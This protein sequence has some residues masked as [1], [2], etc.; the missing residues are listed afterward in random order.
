[1]YKTYIA[2]TD[3]LKQALYR[4]RYQIFTMEQRKYRNS[5]DHATQTLV[6]AIDPHAEH[7][8]LESDGNLIGSMRWLHG[9]EHLP[10]T[11]QD[12]LSLARFSKFPSS[13][14]SFC[15]RLFV[16]PSHRGTPALLELVRFAF[17]RAQVKGTYFD[18]IFCN[19]HLV[20]M[21][22]ALGYRRYRPYFEDPGLGFQVPMVFVVDDVAHLQAIH[23][24]VAHLANSRKSSPEYVDWF[25]DSFPEYRQF[26]SPIVVGHDLFASILSRKINDVSIELFAGL[27]ADPDCPEG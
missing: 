6:D 20:R 26:V 25:N 9:M 19:P 11:A 13:E 18:F 3:E 4:L 12:N 17:E 8:C 21:Y 27:N 2:D 7:F 24:P 14:F 15:G 1:M 5:A 22:E 10:R 23:S 16:M